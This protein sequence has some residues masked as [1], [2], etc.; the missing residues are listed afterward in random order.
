MADEV[1]KKKKSNWD[2]N[3]FKQYDTS[4]G[5]GN[6]E[7]WK[8]AFIKR[9]EA[10]SLH[11]EFPELSQAQT[12]G[13]LKKIYRLLSLKLHPDVEGGSETEFKKMKDLYDKLLPNFK[14]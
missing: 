10:I 5:K 6:P 9:T 7:S 3:Q 2:K 11:S 12:K 8:E 1:K 4:T 14:K 13:E